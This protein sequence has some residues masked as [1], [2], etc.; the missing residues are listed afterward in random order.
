MIAR[1]IILIETHDNTWGTLANT[2]HVSGRGQQSRTFA[3]RRGHL[4]VARRWQDNHRRRPD[5][6]KTIISEVDR[7]RGRCDDAL[8][9]RSR[10]FWRDYLVAAVLAADRFNDGNYLFTINTLRYSNKK[11][12][13]NLLKNNII[14]IFIIIWAN[15]RFL[16]DAFKK[17]FY[18]HIKNIHETFI[19]KHFAIT[20][21]FVFL[22]IILYLYWSIFDCVYLIKN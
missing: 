11:L 9:I 20:F 12:F 4:S 17:I 6:N 22:I 13:G 1:Q 2:K 7:S 8:A 16:G 15:N 21:W 14:L 3:N 5:P 10:T 18:P 19:S